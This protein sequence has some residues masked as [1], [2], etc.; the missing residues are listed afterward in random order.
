MRTRGAHSCVRKMPTGLPLWT[1]RVSSC[2]RLRSERTIASKAS[3]LRAARPVPPYTTRS[4][5]RSATS[6][7]RLFISIRSAA[8]CCQPLQESEVP[9]GARMTR[10]PRVDRPGVIALEV[11][12]IFSC[13]GEL[14]ALDRRRHELDVRRKYAIAGERRN[15]TPNSRLS[16]RDTAPGLERQSIIDSLRGAH[17]LDGQHVTHV[18][19]DATQLPR[20]THRHRNDILLVSVGRNGVDARRV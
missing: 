3:Q 7:S 15:E 18:P 4:S 2:A 19:H 20:R 8:S 10:A 14:S 11:M 1:S 9:R 6:G 12:M 16:A 5:G 17:Q 13:H